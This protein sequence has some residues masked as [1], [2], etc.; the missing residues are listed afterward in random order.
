MTA[1]RCIAPLG[2]GDE[3]CGE[4]ATET[5]IVEGLECP[6]CMAHARELDEE[7]DGAAETARPRQPE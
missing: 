5:R 1:P 2:D 3:L 7:R 6:L 4:P